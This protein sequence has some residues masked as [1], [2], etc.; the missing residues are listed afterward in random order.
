MSSRKARA[1]SFGTPNFRSRAVPANSC[2]LPG[3]VNSSGCSTFPILCVA[4]P[5]KT[6]SRSSTN[7][8]K[9][10]CKRATNLKATSCTSVRCATRRGGALFSC[11]IAFTCSGSGHSDNSWLKGNITLRCFS[12]FTSLDI[13]DELS[14]RFCGVS[15]SATDFPFTVALWFQP[16]HPK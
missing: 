13:S 3:D 12:Y 6:L 16:R 15:N 5:N 1:N 9:Q 2:L 14:R 8:G 4:A 11:K 10:S 7:C